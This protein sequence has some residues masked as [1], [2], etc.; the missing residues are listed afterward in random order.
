MTISSATEYTAQILKQSDARVIEKATHIKLLSLDV[1]GVLTDGGLIYGEHGEIQ[2]RFNVLDGLGIKQLI[3]QGIEVII[4]TAKQSAMLTARCNDL[5]LKHVFQNVPDKGATLAKFA[6]QRGLQKNQMAHM[7][8]D[9]PDLKA[10]QHCG[11][12]LT[13]ANAHPLLVQ[14]A[15]WQSSLQG[16]YGAVREASDLLLAAQDK[17]TAAVDA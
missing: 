1:D 15:D 3:Q 9:L 2:K 6:Q 13:V 17:L 10:M 16:G 14:Q 11:L 7:G 8:D 5:G 12:K 4:I